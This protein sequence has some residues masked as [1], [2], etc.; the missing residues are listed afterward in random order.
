MRLRLFLYSIF[1]LLVCALGGVA[2]DVRADK[3]VVYLVGDSTVRTTRDGHAGWGDAL[4]PWL[5]P[6]NPPRMENHARGG[7]STRS[8][9][10]SGDWEELRVSL[11]QGDV[12][13]IQFG[14]NDQGQ[15]KDGK[16]TLDGCG[17]AT[18][19]LKG[20]KGKETVVH[21]YGWYLNR[22]IDE[23][24]ERKAIPVIVTPVPRNR[25]H[26]RKVTT[27]NQPHAKWARQVAAARHVPVL[28]L[29]KLVRDHYEQVGQARVDS[30]YFRAK[31]ETHTTLEG[32]SV[33][34]RLAA[35][36]L[37]A[38]PDA[39]VRHAFGGE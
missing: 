38:H 24:L 10:D 19:I 27:S 3:P 8:F 32:A 13:L 37:R 35:A 23:I 6:A 28:D 18:T 2:V 21:S 15:P 31:D 29:N 14:H 4:M 33:T 7:A 1:V 25:W 39:N 17:D 34:A 26:G 16:A 30:R 12:V 9:R 20:K 11:K 22:Y 5:P 36:A